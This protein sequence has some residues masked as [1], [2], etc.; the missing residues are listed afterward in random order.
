[1]PFD[2]RIDF[3]GLCLYLKQRDSNRMAV[4]MPDCRKVR[5]NDMKHDDDTKG[6]PHVG[7]IRF[8]LA[9]LVGSVPPGTIEFG[10]QYEVVYRFHRQHLTFNLPATE[11]PLRGELEVPRFEEIANEKPSSRGASPVPLLEPLPGL[12][13]EKADKLPLL[14][15]TFLQGGSLTADG[16]EFWRF[17]R[18]FRR[19]VATT[20][21]RDFKSIVT[22]KRHVDD[23]VLTI[24]I[25]DFD[26]KNS[27]DIPLRPLTK[28]GVIPLKIANL[29]TENPLEW[30]EFEKRLVRGDDEDFKWLYRLLR[31]TEGRTY[32]DLLKGSGAKLRKFPIPQR[33]QAGGAGREDCFGGAQEVDSFD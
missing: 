11:D 18:V 24:T 3:T 26:G 17:S 4:L 28:G 10:P 16:K 13:S 1:M 7:Y 20:Y 23:D 32:R 14:M 21:E 15:R 31:P 6:V 22:W 19:G 33:P 5:G 8:D 25:A 30:D 9:N 29:C 27:V 2:L 12:F